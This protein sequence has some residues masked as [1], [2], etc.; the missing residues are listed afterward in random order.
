MGLASALRG[1]AVAEGFFTIHR[2]ALE[3]PLFKNDPARLGA[4]VWML[5]EACWQ[6][7]RHNIGG[8]TVTLERGQFCASVRRMGDEWKWSKSAVGRFLTRLETETMI[9]REA[10]HGRLI[11]TVCNY[12]KYQDAG[13]AKRDSSGTLSGTAAGQQRDLKEQGNKETINKEPPKAPRKRWVGK[14]DSVSDSLWGEWRDYRKSVF[15]ETALAGF[16]READKAGWTISAAL[17]ESMERGW[18]G[19]KADWV[20]DKSNGRS[21]GNGNHDKRDGVAKAL[22]RRIGLDPFAGPAERSD[23]GGDQ[24]IGAGTTARLTDLR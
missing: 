20:K 13:K 21:N 19:F 22:D 10:G 2:R 23:A 3:H 16:Q 5:S 24:R 15:T 4:W 9:E 7:T 12:A 6:P 18:Q 8:K 17:T 1:C 11:I 14:P